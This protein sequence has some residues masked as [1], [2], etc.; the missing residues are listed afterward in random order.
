M[1][2]HARGDD[3][4]ARKFDRHLVQT[5]P[6]R[7]VKT[8]RPHEIWRTDRCEKRADGKVD[9]TPAAMVKLKELITQIEGALLDE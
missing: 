2:T 8:T 6:D 4:H 7:P 9:I 1:H 3:G 5:V